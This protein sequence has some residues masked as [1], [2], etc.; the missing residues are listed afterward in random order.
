VR[1]VLT[2]AKTSRK[3][4]SVIGGLR[5][6]R[7]KKKTLLR[8]KNMLGHATLPLLCAMHDKLDVFMAKLF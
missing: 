2:A 5:D 4:S 7:E 1:L 8:L 6:Q 3:L